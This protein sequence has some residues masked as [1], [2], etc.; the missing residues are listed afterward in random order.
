MHLWVSISIPAQ[1]SL[2]IDSNGTQ[3]FA[4]DSQLVETSPSQFTLHKRM[5]LS[6]AMACP[7]QLVRSWLRYSVYAHEAP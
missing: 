2:C 3:G 1:I 6:L 5:R 4:K 7:F